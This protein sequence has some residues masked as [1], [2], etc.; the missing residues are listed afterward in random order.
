MAQRPKILIR[1]PINPGVTTSPLMCLGGTQIQ[2]VPE[3]KYLGTVITASHNRKASIKARC[4]KAIGNSKLLTRFIKEHKIEWKIARLM[5]KMV[6]SPTMTYGLNVTSLTKANRSRLRKYERYILKEM[7]QVAKDPPKQK[8]HNILEGKTIT[9]IIK[10][11][12][13]SYYGHVI[14]R[15]APHLLQAAMVYKEPRKK[16][17][18]PIYTW[19]DSLTHDIYNY[20]GKNLESWKSIAA[21]RKQI[22]KEAEEIYKARETDTESESEEANENANLRCTNGEAPTEEQSHVL[23]LF[24]THQV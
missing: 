21:D 15:Q 5:Y 13:I 17:G 22:K 18:R 1:D 8:I 12:R 4:R 16:I 23:P 10:V 2:P 24:I 6:I 19:E 3:L 20:S 7:L 9:K 14:R 11:R